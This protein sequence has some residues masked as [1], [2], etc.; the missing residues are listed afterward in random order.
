MNFVGLKIKKYNVAV[1]NIKRIFNN[2]QDIKDFI[3]CAQQFHQLAAEEDDHD[4]RLVYFLMEARAYYFQST[5]NPGKAEIYANKALSLIDAVK[6]QTRYSW[7]YYYARAIESNCYYKLKIPLDDE[8]WLSI[9]NELEEF[10]EKNEVNWNDFYSP[11]V[12]EDVYYALAAYY[13]QR[14]IRNN[15]LRIYDDAQEKNDE[16]KVLAE[17]MSYYQK[18]YTE[19]CVYLTE[20]SGVRSRV[21][22]YNALIDFYDS[23]INNVVISLTNYSSF[24]TQ[25]DLV[26]NVFSSIEVLSNIVDECKSCLKEFDYNNQNVRMYIAF[27]RIIAKALAMKAM[28]YRL[29]NNAE[30]EAQQANECHDIVAKML[31]LPDIIDESAI[32]EISYI[33]S[34]MFL[35]KTFTKDDIDYF[36]DNSVKVLNSNLYKNDSLLRKENTAY[37]ICEDCRQIIEKYGYNEKIYDLGLKCVEEL[38]T[39]SDILQNSF[40]NKGI[41]E[42]KSFFENYAKNSNTKTNEIHVSEVSQDEKD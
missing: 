17:K 30:Q 23:Q 35:T 1:E 40:D 5:L 10:T 36:H 13:K 38:R 15:V 26:A 31:R 20:D 24:K 14:A 33:C 28:F 2:M 18:L 12:F 42:L 25:Q 21:I 8:K 39:Y 27:N 7:M 19:F 6:K 41:M 4:F 3:P 32:Y 29:F 16:I 22:D 37:L 34:Y 11:M 9:I